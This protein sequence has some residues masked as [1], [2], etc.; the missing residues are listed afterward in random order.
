MGSILQW[1]ERV[2]WSAAAG[3]AAEVRR[4][5]SG[6][7]THGT[8]RIRVR[9]GN[10]A[11]LRLEQEYGHKFWHRMNVMIF[12]RDGRAAW[13]CNVVENKGLNHDQMRDGRDT[14]GFRWR[15][16]WFWSYAICKLFPSVYEAK[17]KGYGGSRKKGMKGRKERSPSL[18]MGVELTRRLGAVGSWAMNRRTQRILL[19]LHSLPDVFPHRRKPAIVELSIKLRCYCACHSEG[20]RVKLDMDRQS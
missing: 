2:L 5:T 12:Y 9:F 16:S 3:W 10:Q 4:K 13:V 8:G 19:V 17:R 1:I 15:R 6:K 7:T 14:T 11:P 18:I 20:E